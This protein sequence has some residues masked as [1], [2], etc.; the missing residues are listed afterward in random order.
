MNHNRGASRDSGGE[1]LDA[2]LAFRFKFGAGTDGSDKESLRRRTLQLSHTKRYTL[3][4]ADEY[5]FDLL[6]VYF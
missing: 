5:G 1:S 3:K 6:A 4:L 2:R